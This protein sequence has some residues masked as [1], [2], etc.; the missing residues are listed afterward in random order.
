MAEAV[1]GWSIALYLKLCSVM[2]DEVMYSMTVMMSTVMQAFKWMQPCRPCTWL[3]SV[4]AFQILQHWSGA[5]YYVWHAGFIKWQH[6]WLITIS[7]EDSMIENWAMQPAS[8]LVTKQTCSLQTKSCVAMWLGTVIRTIVWPDVLEV[9]YI[10]MGLITL[11]CPSKPKY[12][13][14]VLIG[15]GSLLLCRLFRVVTLFCEMPERVDTAH[16]W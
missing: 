6:V 12:T 10:C 16:I 9:G 2:S 4:Q 3:E 13:C 8:Q 14:A 11:L 1:F 15:Q 7:T 5:I